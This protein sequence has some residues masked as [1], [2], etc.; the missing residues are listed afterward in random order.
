[1]C[2]DIVV[3]HC[4][5]D[6]MWVNELRRGLAPRWPSRGGSRSPAHSSRVILLLAPRWPS[7]VHVL[8]KCRQRTAG[9]LAPGVTQ[10]EELNFG[11]EAQAYLAHIV[12]HYG[13]R[14]GG[15]RIAG[16]RIDAAAGGRRG[17]LSL[18]AGGGG[19]EG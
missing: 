19:G 9:L 12:R 17:V 11:A 15:L 4:K 14:V 6:L 7:R 13:W 3:A 2:I 18:F 5:E 8:N 16:R 10:R 1:M